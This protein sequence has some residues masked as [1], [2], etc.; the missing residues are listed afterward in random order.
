MN[1]KGQTRIHR[2]APEVFWEADAHGY[3]SSSP[4]DEDSRASEAAG[5]ARDLQV[6][7]ARESNEPPSRAPEGSVLSESMEAPAQSESRSSQER[8][9][10]TS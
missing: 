4:A 10:Q 1:E 3:K 6:M 9:Q 7:E 2:P 5:G 8:L